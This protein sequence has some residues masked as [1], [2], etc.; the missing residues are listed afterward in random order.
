MLVLIKS[1]LLIFLN[2]INFF[3]SW[4]INRLTRLSIV[5][6]G[7]NAEEKNE[8]IGSK[9]YKV[10]TH[11]ASGPDDSTDKNICLEFFSL[12]NF[13]EYNGHEAK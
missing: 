7:R 1:K 11:W 5:A 2:F 12:Q 8:Q 13:Q 3:A 10:E 9:I 4:S 6:D